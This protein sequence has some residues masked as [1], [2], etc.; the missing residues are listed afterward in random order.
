MAEPPRDAEERIIDKRMWSGIVLIGVVMGF[1]TLLTI[2]IFLPGGL[3]EGNDS[4]EVARTAGF[5]TLVLAQLFNALNSRSESVSAFHHLFTNK[6]LW[7]S[8]ALGVVLQVAVVELAFLQAMF[9]TAS[10][11]LVHWAVCF[12]MASVVLWFDE[13]R[14]LVGRAVHR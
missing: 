2:D 10:M 12:A 7:G 6:W 4:L 14:K 5:T 1:A 11:D 8:L 3:I 13:L 9:G